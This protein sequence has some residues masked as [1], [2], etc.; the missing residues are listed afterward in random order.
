MGS[1][2]IHIIPVKQYTVSRELRSFCTAVRVHVHGLL[3]NYGSQVGGEVGVACDH[4]PDLA[5]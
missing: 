5:P 1:T 3:E 2:V 4:A